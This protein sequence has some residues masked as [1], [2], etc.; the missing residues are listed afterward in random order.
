MSLIEIE[1]AAINGD[2]IPK[3]LKVYDTMLYYML[4][5]LYAKYKARQLTKEEAKEHKQAIMSVYKRV[6]DDYEQFT[7]ICKEYQRRL[8]DVYLKM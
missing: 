5:G 3:D 7:A 2:P 4:S 6:K 1:K 8:K